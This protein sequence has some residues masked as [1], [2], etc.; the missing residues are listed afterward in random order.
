MKKLKMAKLLVY[1][2]P[3]T[4]FVVCLAL[5]AMLL[6]GDFKQAG[7]CATCRL[8]A[9]ISKDENIRLC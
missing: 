6:S 2:L 7:K 4:P 8:I 5:P 9:A 1:L 3:L